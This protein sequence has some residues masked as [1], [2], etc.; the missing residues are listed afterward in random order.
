M[1]TQAL[2]T[3]A[4]AQQ[5]Q[6]A[7]TPSALL[8]QLQPAADGRKDAYTLTPTIMQAI[9]AQYPAGTRTSPT[10]T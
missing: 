6:R 2:V 10:H 7:G 8:W 1:A 4:L 5:T 9:M 3:A